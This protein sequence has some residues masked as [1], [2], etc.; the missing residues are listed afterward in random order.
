MVT[1]NIGVLAE[2]GGDAASLIEPS[3]PSALAHAAI[4][5]LEN[6]DLQNE[7]RERGRSRSHLYRWDR[8]AEQ[9]SEVYRR[10][11]GGRR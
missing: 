6:S 3:D 11:L 4:G 2:V 1:S 8:A 10:L 9:T 7:L 5:I